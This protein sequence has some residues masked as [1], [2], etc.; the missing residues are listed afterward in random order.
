MKKERSSGADNPA[1]AEQADGSPRH[2]R[3]YPAVGDG[4]GFPHRE[5]LVMAHSRRAF[6]AASAS[7]A[8]ATL[9]AGCSSRTAGNAGQLGEPRIG[10]TL[11]YLEPQTWTSLYPPSAGFYANGG[12]VNNITDRLLHQ[13]PE[14][15]ELEPW[16]AA[17]LPSVNEDATEYT[18]K[19]RRGVTY[20]DGT[21]LDAANV[22]KNFDLYGRGDAGKV[23]TASEA[24]NN[25]DRGEVVDEHTVRFHFSAPAPGFA[26][27]TSTINSGLLSN[28]TLA[29]S[30]KGFGP[31]NAKSIIGSGP[32]VITEEKVGTE[33]RLAARQDYSWAPPSSPHQGRPLLDEINV[34]V[35]GEDSV[36]VGTVVA[37]QAN[38]ARQIEAPDEPQF[39]TEELALHVAA[40]NGVNNGLSFRF[41]TPQ[42]SDIRVRQ[43]IIAGIDRQ[44]I[45]D[46]LFT[47][48]YPLATGALARTALGHVDTS[49]N[50]VHDPAKAAA[51]LDQ[52]G[53]TAGP[54]KIRVKD[55]RRLA[56]TFNEALPQP[57]SKEVVT[58]I[59]AQ[60]AK[61]GIQVELFP[62][63]YA[64]QTAAALDPDQIQVYHSMVGRADFDVLKSQYSSENRNA[65]LNLNTD[66]GSTGD[67]ELEARL[68]AIAS[69]PTVEQREQ[70]SAAAQQWLADQAYILPIFE[71]PQVFGLRAEVRGFATESVGRPSFYRT[72]LNA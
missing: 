4:P 52:A 69:R 61:I 60:L 10:G 12:I 70:A 30:N 22:V 68:S 27:A 58:L 57:R 71:E 15:L 26:Q 53:W 38:I 55:G 33:L 54:D 45:V 1:R 36:R 16:I 13:N 7:I 56:L 59:Q 21:P 46:T 6:L 28:A 2:P 32:F 24:I 44:A 37:G 50:Y 49:A 31:G 48:S 14:T 11:I 3:H 39:S 62:G 41:R 64:A 18:F 25:Y 63:D 35:T 29:K 34:V 8:V 5:V 47:K 65:L 51:L 72:W 67:G 19:L 23:L 17:E 9:A 42:L 66:E 40:T 20:S 43:A